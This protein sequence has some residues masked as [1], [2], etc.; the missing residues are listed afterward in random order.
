[1]TTVHSEPRFDVYRTITDKIVHAIETGVDPC[2]MPWHGSGGQITRPANAATGA[3]YRG[4][5]VIAL[6]AEAVTRGYRSGLWAS[7]RQWQHLGAQ[8]RAGE[9]GA[10]IVFFKE[11]EPEDIG[12]ANEEIDRPKLMA[13]ASRVFGAEQVEGWTPPR[14]ELPSRV[15]AIAAVERFVVATKADIRLGLQRACYHGNGDYIEM[16]SPE[17]FC[18]TKTSSPTESYYAVLLH[19]LSHWTGAEHR[20]GRQLGKRFGEAAYAMEELIAELGAAFLCADLGVTCEPRPDHAAYIQSWLHMLQNDRK[21]IFTAA[22]RA[23]Q[24]V[25][26]LSDLTKGKS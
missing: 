13:R 2:T 15:Q 26:F 1:M 20:L 8:V 18:G 4:V 7:Y 21:A 9:R 22:S 25:D 17:S 24:V 23:S 19:E 5:N 11:H 14:V 12:Q 3:A 16:P 10:T 6:W